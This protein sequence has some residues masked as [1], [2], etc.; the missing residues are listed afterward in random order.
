MLSS[1]DFER[2]RNSTEALFRFRFRFV[3]QSLVTILVDRNYRSYYQ[4]I[5]QSFIGPIIITIRM[6]LY[7][8]FLSSSTLE[9]VCRVYLFT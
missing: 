8:S 9:F 2:L 3:H 7:L 6:S 1:G 4:S 5:M